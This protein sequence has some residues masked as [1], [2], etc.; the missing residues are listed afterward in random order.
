MILN[1]FRNQIIADIKG[2]YEVHTTSTTDSIEV[3]NKDKVEK[4]F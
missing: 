4:L 3:E 2:R 1:Y